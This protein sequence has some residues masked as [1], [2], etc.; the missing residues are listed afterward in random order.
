MQEF[1]L[2]FETELTID[3]YL[4]YIDSL[5]FENIQNEIIQ[6]KKMITG[7]KNKRNEV[8]FQRRK[9]LSLFFDLYSN[10]L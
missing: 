6:F 1:T 4:Q 2:E 7:F 5:N 10:S 9:Y 8:I 3:F